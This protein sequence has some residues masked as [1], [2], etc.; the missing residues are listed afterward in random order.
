MENKCASTCGNC[1]NGETC[2]NVN[3]TCTDG[4]NEGFKGIL[5]KTS[6]VTKEPHFK[7]N[8]VWN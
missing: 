8:Y 6:M 5:C 1:L 7:D 4:C 2:D 3:G